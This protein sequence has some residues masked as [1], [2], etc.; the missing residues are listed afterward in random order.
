MNS[1]S[2]FTN[3][4]FINEGENGLIYKATNKKNNKIYVIKAIKDNN[5][6]VLIDREKNLLKNESHQNIIRYYSSFVENNINY[7]VL[8]FFDGEDL[9]HLSN[10]YKSEN[11]PK[12]IPESLI[13]I[14]LKGVINGLIYLHNR[15]IMHRDITPDNIMID[16][17]NVVKITDF[18][19]SKKCNNLDELAKGSLRGKTHYTSPE[20]SKAYF[21]GQQY[22]NY[23][24]KTDIFSLGVT[25]FNIMTFDFPLNINKKTKTFERNENFIDPNI[26]NRK[27]IELVESMLIFDENLRPS[28][29]DLY[30]EMRK[31]IGDK[32]MSS[33]YHIQ[34][35]EIN[36]KNNFGIIRSAFSTVILYFLNVDK[37]K[38]YFQSNLVK[39][40]IKEKISPNLRIVINSFA[41]ILNNFEDKNNNRS[42][43]ITKFIVK[44]SQKILIFKDE[45]EAK[46]TPKLVIRIL[47]EYFYYAFNKTKDIFIYNNKNAYILYE[48]I[49][50]M[51][52][53]D[54]GLIEKINEFILNYAN[55]FS[56]TF[57][58]PI[59]KKISCPI[60]NEIED[61]IEIIY[62]IEFPQYGN[63]NQLLEEYQSKNSV[64]NYNNKIC[65]NC[66]ALPMNFI[67]TKSLIIAPNILIFHFNNGAKLEEYIE[68]KEYINCNNKVLYKIDA[69]INLSINNIYNIAIYNAINNNWIYYYNEK[70]NSIIEF[71]KVIENGKICIAFYKIYKNENK[72]Y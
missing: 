2:D 72:D 55:I 14:I 40:K 57:Y 28:S 66:Y 65:K 68:I 8:E 5:N 21:K 27:L 17:N 48:K 10:K 62:D 59:L 16:N 54:R 44:I 12:Y 13:I 35:N 23:N 7:F 31:L 15:N 30:N 41:E 9:E 37:I 52:N 1:L 46:I 45:D 38:D 60:C 24:F 18:G 3:F 20:I 53:I 32:M 51:P 33:T 56:D 50:D 58:F 63:I 39:D 6:R 42:N 70:N 29:L 22:T 61:S 26:Y 67:E 34:Q 4:V 43:L 71:N 36:L 25:M 49:K 11:P 69:I 19:I 47:F 64:R